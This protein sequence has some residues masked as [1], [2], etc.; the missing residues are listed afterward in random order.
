MLNNEAVVK[1]LRRG[2]GNGLTMGFAL[3]NEDMG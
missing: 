1:L 3:V 2:I